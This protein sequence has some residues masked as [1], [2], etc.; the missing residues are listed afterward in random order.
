MKKRTR[1]SKRQYLIG[2]E[3]IMQR[4]ITGEAVLKI[5]MKKWPA[6]GNEESGIV[7]N[8]MV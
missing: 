1:V 7:S 3:K 4:N 6:V 8:T 5:A 2:E